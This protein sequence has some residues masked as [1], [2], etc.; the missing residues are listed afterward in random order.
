MQN[1]LFIP[2]VITTP[3]LGGGGI[4]VSRFVTAS[5]TLL[6]KLFPVGVPFKVLSLYPDSS[7][8][9]HLGTY[10]VGI[11]LHGDYQ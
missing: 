5:K 1:G 7:Y 4:I 11:H 9:A 3:S 2:E 6:A 10:N 8:L